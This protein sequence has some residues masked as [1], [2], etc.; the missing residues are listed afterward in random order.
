MKRGVPVLSVNAFETRKAFCEPKIA[1]NVSETA[2][3][4]EVWV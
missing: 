3:E 4:R 2:R 1:A